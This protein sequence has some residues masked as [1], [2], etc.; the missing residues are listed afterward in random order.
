MPYQNET[1]FGL[2]GKWAVPLFLLIQAFHTYKY[3]YNNRLRF[4]KILNRVII[5]FFIVEV[6]LVSIRYIEGDLR[7][8][9]S[10]RKL[11]SMGGSGAG[12]YYPYI[13]VQFAIFLFIFGKIFSRIKKIYWVYVV[14][15]SSILLECLFC[16]INTPEYV[17]RLL[18][19]RYVFIAWGGVLLV[20]NNGIVIN[21]RTILLSLISIVFIVLFGYYDFSLYPIFF[22]SDESWKVCHWL[23]YFYSFFL[24]PFFLHLSINILPKFIL[25]LVSLCGRASYEIFLV[26]MIVFSI[27]KNSQLTQFHNNSYLPYLIFVWLFSVIGG[28]CWYN[29]K[30]KH[31]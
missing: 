20:E 7:N 3:G 10:V 28:V 15:M 2:W 14:L 25:S 16:I 22:D 21:N 5:P 18:C 4:G 6:L 9:E 19:V 29:I 30:Q 8:V 17:W 12:C 27:V 24:L 1:L 31:Q 23:C 13:Y 11:I 26:Q